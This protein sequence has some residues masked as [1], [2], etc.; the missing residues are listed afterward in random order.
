MAH[1]EFKAPVI[2]LHEADGFIVTVETKSGELYRGVLEGSEDT[3]N[4]QMKDVTYTNP[5]GVDS[6]IDSVYIRGSNIR[7]FVLPD[8]L[9]NSPMFINNNRAVKGLANG[10]AGNLR[11]KKDAQKMRILYN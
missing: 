1:P 9:A 6:H 4:C 3:M 5:D 10:F 2:L 8:M 7:F 11:D